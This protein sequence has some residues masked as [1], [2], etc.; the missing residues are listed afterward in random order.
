[1]KIKE[2][3]TNPQFKYIYITFLI[4]AIGFLKSFVLLKFFE[5]DKLGIVALAQTFTSSISLMQIGV[6]TGGYRL[7]SYKKESILKKVNETVFFF[8]LI[9]TIFLCFLG[10]VVS[11]FFSIGVS[12]LFCQLFILIGVLS[13]Y[14]NWVV[15]K[16]LG[17]RNI[18]VVNKAQA[19]SAI[20]SFFITLGA[21]WFG[22]TA[23]LTAL[24]LQPLIIIGVAYLFSPILMPSLNF[25]SFKKYI[26][27]IISLGFIPYLTSA[28]TLL[29]SQLGRWLITFS[30]GTIIL[31]KT[32]LPALFVV[33][34][35]VFPSAISSLFFPKIIENF[36]KNQNENLVKTL[37]NYF[38]I[39]MIYYSLVITVTL[40]LAN[41][42]IKIFLPKQVE[43]IYL[44]YAVLP[45]VFFLH[46]SGPAIFLFN[47]MKKFNNIL[48]GGLISVFS[49]CFFLCLYLYFSKPQLVYFF[50][51]ESVSALLFFVY[52]SYYFIKLNKSLNYVK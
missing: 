28:L 25:K 26:K 16:L 34:V 19:A 21:Y 48:I 52:N 32:F 37:K 10:F 12:A 3:V 20:V 8:F 49:Y 50:I 29:N 5:F 1:M 35:S 11:C 44:I 14:S 39:L 33:L 4:S 27:K 15:C 46:L 7:F 18:K 13:L 47:A 45:S 9:I 24:F 6:I 43:S 30:L 42:M 17:T 23:V 36:E 51:I 40:L 41:I 38:A 31:G 2:L 22:L